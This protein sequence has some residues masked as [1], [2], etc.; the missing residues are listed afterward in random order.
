MNNRTRK[1]LWIAPIAAVSISWGALVLAPI[2]AAPHGTSPT[3]PDAVASAAVRASESR[4]P[5][6]Q[7][8]AADRAAVDPEPSTAQQVEQLRPLDD[9]ELSKRAA[10][11]D[12]QIERAGYV[13]QANAGVLAGPDI[14]RFKAMLRQRNAVQ[15]AKAERLLAKLEA[16][17]SR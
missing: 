10:E 14:A 2:A 5:R 17:V 3:R 7:P 9:T 15:I 8:S 11:V 4:P 16:P 13:Q 12:E 6:S 1:L